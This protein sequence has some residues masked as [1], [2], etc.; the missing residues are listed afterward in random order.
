MPL[1]ARAVVHMLW[2]MEAEPASQR[3]LRVAVPTPPWAGLLVVVVAATAIVILPIT[4]TASWTWHLTAAVLLAALTVTAIM[5]SGPAPLR[6]LIYLNLAFLVFALATH[7]QWPP[8]VTA[9]LVC[10]L[11]LAVLLAGSRGSRLRPSAPW[12]RAGQRPGATVLILALGTVVA[13]GAAL[14]MWTVV[15]TPAAPPYLAQLQRYPAGLA[16][17]GVIGFAVVNPTWEEAMFRGVILE[18]LTVLW[19]AGPAVIVQ[20]VLFGAAHWAGFPSGWVGMLMAAGWGLVRRESSGS[21]RVAFS[22]LTWSMS[23]RTRP[24]AAS[25]RANCMT[26]PRTNSRASP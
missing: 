9:V 1:P 24:S 8:A 6:T 17:L 16:V 14:A 5:V 20:A 21:G 25:W 10:L 2:A 13:A 12:L 22:F 11:P 15:V 26:S 7:V 19:G 4:V 18:D 23:R 3:D